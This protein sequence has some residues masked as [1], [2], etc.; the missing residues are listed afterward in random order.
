MRE[1][2]NYTL[3]ILAGC[4]AVRVAAWMT[5]PVLVPLLALLV[6]L[7]VACMLRRG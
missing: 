1:L 6:G 3:L 4:M 7:Q 2:R 5:E